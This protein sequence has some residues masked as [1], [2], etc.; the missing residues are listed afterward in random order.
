MIGL[1]KKIKKV[2][3][4]IVVVLLL[5]LVKMAIAANPVFIDVPTTIEAPEDQTY[6]F[7]VTA[8]DPDEEYPLNFTDD[9]EEI[10]PVFY[11][12]KLNS[13][14]ALINFT[15]TNDDVNEH[16]GGVHISII[17]KDTS[18]ESALQDV[19]VNITN[20]NDPPN[21]TSYWPTDL[22]PSVAENS[23]AGF[24]V[25]YSASDPDTP[26][27]DVLTVEWLKDGVNQSSNITW[28]YRP[29]W[30]E[31]GDYNI[32]LNVTDSYNASDT[33]TWNLT[34]TNTNRKPVLNNTLENIS[35]TE[36][37]NSTNVIDLDE[38]FYDNDTIEC[39]GS[40]KDTLIFNVTGNSS[41]KVIINTSDNKV[42]FNPTVNWFG[43]ETIYFTAYDSYNTT[44]SNNITINVTNVND[45]PVL[46]EI[47][48]QSFAENVSFSLTVT[49]SDPDNDVV[50]GTDTL[51]FYDNTTM[52]DID[53][54]TGVISFTPQSSDVSNHTV[55]ITVGDGSLNDSQVVWFNVSSNN[56]PVLDAVG[57]QT[58]EEATAFSMTVTASDADGDTLT[59]SSNY[60]RFTVTTISST[61]AS[62]SFT[63]NNDDVGNHS[64]E[65]FVN[66]S[67]NAVDSEVIWLNISNINNPPELDAIENQSI[68]LNKTKYLNVTAS[69]AD[70]DDLTFYTNDSKFNVT[71]VDNS[72]GS[73]NF[74]FS[75]TD[76]IGN[77]TVNV[78]VSDGAKNDSQL[79]G[80]FIYDN[81]PPVFESISKQ[82]PQED[83]IFFLNISANDPD[84][85]N[86]TFGTNSTLFNLTHV[87]AS[88]ATLNYLQCKCN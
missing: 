35:L 62:F 5:C 50:S 73:F 17:V 46:D 68:T 49:A 86:L 32:T 72:Y 15:P 45:A 66:D 53:P 23:S 10:V 16:T 88:M 40:N 87:N 76:D 2:E 75:S 71:T 25:N 41:V 70:N 36:D 21:I 52:F 38:Y 18:F 3:F 12:S 30:C 81:R 33:Q 22:T 54:S 4:L 37:V 64:I 24:S 55:N 60:S 28:T 14:A 20:T 85:D 77:Y 61:S 78:T 47:A 29:S 58:A 48:G 39:S 34:V 9:S 84:Y 27:G 82:S 65:I 26:Y 51:T 57:S 79:V 7:N 63:P 74:T 6:Y 8:S 83:S 31:A 69:D 13:T 42:S 67:W 44:D 11:M 43:N 56:A 1:I 80:F 19:L 59:F